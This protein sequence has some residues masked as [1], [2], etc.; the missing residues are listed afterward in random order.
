[1]GHLSYGVAVASFWSV[2]S[3]KRRMTGWLFS[4]RLRALLHRKFT[5]WISSKYYCH[6]FMAPWL[7]MMGFGLDGW[8][9]WPL[10]HL[11]PLVL[12][13]NLQLEPPSFTAEN[14]LHSRTRSTTATGPCQ[15]V[16]VT[17]RQAVYRQS[18]RLGAKPLETHRHIIFFSIDHLRS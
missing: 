9:Y 1:M 2:C 4:N 10:L 16:R 11:E 17:L 12:T 5:V 6:E 14:S 7:I 3:L 13:I 8:I 15:R 18:V